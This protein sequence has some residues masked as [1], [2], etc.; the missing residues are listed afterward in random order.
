MDESK[1]VLKITPKAS[2]DLN[3]IYDYIANSLVNESAAKNLMSRIEE[4]IIVFCKYFLQKVCC[5]TRTDQLLIS[6]LHQLD[7]TMFMHY[8][9]S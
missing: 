4:K 7:G 8:L 2:A 9:Q 6:C 1:Y 5:Q 3:E